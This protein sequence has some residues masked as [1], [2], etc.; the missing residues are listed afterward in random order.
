M[1]KE[2]KEEINWVEFNELVF[3]RK[4][5]KS[6]YRDKNSIKIFAKIKKG[7]LVYYKRDNLIWVGE[8]KK[9]SGKIGL[10]IVNI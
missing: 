6:I 3:N 8:V 10:E 4:N 1:K 2:T 7:N 9:V 5:P